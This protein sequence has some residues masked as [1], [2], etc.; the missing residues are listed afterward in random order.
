MHHQNHSLLAS[1][2]EQWMGS[3]LYSI[4][5]NRWSGDATNTNKVSLDDEQYEVVSSDEKDDKCY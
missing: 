5:A 4:E 3:Y 2:L 1:R